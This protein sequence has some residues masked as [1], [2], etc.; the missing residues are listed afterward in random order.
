[1]SATTSTTPSTS[2]KERLLNI[3]ND[4]VQIGVP[5]AEKVAPTELPLIESSAVLLE[6]IMAIVKAL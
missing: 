5:V 4:I 2:L 3:A 6:G 1:M